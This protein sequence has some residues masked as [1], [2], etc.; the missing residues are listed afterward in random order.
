VPSYTPSTK[1]GQAGETLL[2]IRRPTN[3]ANLQLDQLG[4][5]DDPLPLIPLIPFPSCKVYLLSNEKYQS[6]NEIAP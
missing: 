4:T 5:Y 3:L 1:K 6:G 2:T